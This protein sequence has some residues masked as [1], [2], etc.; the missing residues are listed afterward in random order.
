MSEEIYFRLSPFN[1][2]RIKN[3][4]PDVFINKQGI[5][6]TEHEQGGV[7]VEYPLGEE[8]IAYAKHIAKHND[9]KLEQEH[10]ECTPADKI[11]HMEINCFQEM[12]K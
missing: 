12:N 8:N 4:H 6:G 7:Q 11:T 9:N 10:E 5:A 1:L 3:V 2:P